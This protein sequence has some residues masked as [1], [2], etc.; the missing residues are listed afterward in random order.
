[1][2]P[3]TVVAFFAA[4]VIGGKKAMHVAVKNDKITNDICS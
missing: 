1:M 4:I 3:L 2:Q